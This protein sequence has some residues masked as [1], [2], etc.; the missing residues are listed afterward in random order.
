MKKGLHL[1]QCVFVQANRLG[2]CRST[3]RR[4]SS[5]KYGMRIVFEPRQLGFE[6]LHSS[7]RVSAGSIC[8]DISAPDFPE[9]AELGRL[10]TKQGVFDFLLADIAA[11][12]GS[13][14]QGS[15]GE[16]RPDRVCTVDGSTRGM[17]SPVL[18][19]KSAAVVVMPLPGV[20][21]STLT[22]KSP[23]NNQPIKTIFCGSTLT[24]T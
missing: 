20:A 23:A 12:G 19:T 1:F 17:G 5:Y 3:C 22:P 24:A 2:V 4:M 14:G 7:K 15:D 11:W 6:H 10:S 16:P 13:A 9:S 18:F 8:S 21:R